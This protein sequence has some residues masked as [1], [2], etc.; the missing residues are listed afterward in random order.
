MHG[1]VERLG[2]GHD[3][4]RGQRLDIC[5]REPLDVFPGRDPA[6]EGVARGGIHDDEG[7]QGDTDH[8]CRGPTPLAVTSMR[9]GAGEVATLDCVRRL[10]DGGLDEAFAAAGGSFFEADEFDD[11]E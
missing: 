5:E 1:E 4:V 2:V 9:Y 11:A 10:G 3:D 8:A 7:E 6:N